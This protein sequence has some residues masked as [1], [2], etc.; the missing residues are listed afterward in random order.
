MNASLVATIGQQHLVAVAM[1]TEH[2]GRLGGMSRTCSRVVE[3]S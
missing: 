2:N 3:A 1:L